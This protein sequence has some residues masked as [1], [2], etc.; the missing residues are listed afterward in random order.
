MNQIMFDSNLLF[1]S[2]VAVTT[3]G[4]GGTTGSA[5][6]KALQVD[7]TPAA[8]LEIEVVVTAAAGSTTGGTLDILIMGSADDS[9][10][11]QVGS[12]ERITNASTGRYIARVQTKKKYLRLD[13]TVGTGTGFSATITAGIVSGGQRD[14][15]S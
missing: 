15:Y 14:L 3:T 2:A 9:T 5:G 6:P 7:K 13:R 4:T 11:T 8:G 1:Y 10:Y 12:F